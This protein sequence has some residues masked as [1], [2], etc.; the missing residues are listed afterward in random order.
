MLVCHC[1]RVTDREVREAVRQGACT[2]DDVAEACG[3]GAGC[4]GCQ[5]LVE[6]LIQLELHAPMSRRPEAYP[7]E[8]P[9]VGS[10]SVRPEACLHSGLSQQRPAPEAA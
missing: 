2:L 1:L 7:S 9:S 4:G 6:R 5:P 10:P 3:A 8:R